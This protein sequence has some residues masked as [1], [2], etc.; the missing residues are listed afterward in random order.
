MKLNPQNQSSISLETPADDP[1]V[2]VSD[3]PDHLAR[4]LHQS[5][6][7]KSYE[8]LMQQYEEQSTQKSQR[9]DQLER[10]L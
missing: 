7:L 4:L 10:D 8:A 3:M 5:T 2:E 9:I 6:L 1:S